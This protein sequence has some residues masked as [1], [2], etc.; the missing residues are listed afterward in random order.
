[1]GVPVATYIQHE[2]G[3]R[4]LNIQTYDEYVEYFAC[5]E[6]SNTDKRNG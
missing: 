4:G 1:M 2:N 6:K 3:T 5:V